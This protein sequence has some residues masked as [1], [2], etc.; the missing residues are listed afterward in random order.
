MDDLTLATAWSLAN[1]FR[2]LHPELAAGSP[3]ERWAAL[4]DRGVRVRGRALRTASPRSFVH[5]TDRRNPVHPFRAE[6]DL[7]SLSG[8][9]AILAV[10]QSRHL[11]CGL[12]LPVDRHQTSETPRQ[13]EEER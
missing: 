11:G 6:V 2:G 9:R 7:G 12:L 8:D 3:R 5:R 1:V 4:S 10:G 13:P